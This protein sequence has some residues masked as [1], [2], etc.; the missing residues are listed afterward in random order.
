MNKNILAIGNAITDIVCNVDKQF[1]LDSGLVEGSMCLIEQNQAK[2]FADLL[3]PNII[4]AGG[5]A[6]NTAATLGLLGVATSFFGVLGADNYADSFVASLQENGVDFIGKNLANQVSASSFILVSESGERT[7][8]THLASAC[9]FAIADMQKIAWQ[10]FHTIYIEG[11]LYDKP[12]T[13]KAINYAIRQ[14]LQHNIKLAFS[15]SDLFCVN[16]HKQDFLNLLPK[17]N[18]LFANKLEIANL[19]SNQQFSLSEIQQFCQINPKLT[20][21]ITDSGNGCF[22][23]NNQQIIQVPTDNIKP[24]DTTGAGDIF[25]SGFLYGLQQ[26]YNLLESAKFANFLARKIITQ[27]GARFNH[28]QITEIKSYA[29]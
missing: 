24:L 11:Y 28:Q 25:A 22:V 13:T 14:A 1:L 8:A 26:N 15:L 4:L 29:K 12:S 27:Y 3:S 5:S 9:D 23:V 20:I 10:N 2:K 6:G 19:C 17:L 21:V 16:R 18:L 7:M